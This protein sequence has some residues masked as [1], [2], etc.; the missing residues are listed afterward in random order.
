MKCIGLFHKENNDYDHAVILST[1]NGT[2]WS[3]DGPKPDSDYAWD[4]L[5]GIEIFIPYIYY[6]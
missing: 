2:A 4:D 6:R 1:E 3:C 5:C